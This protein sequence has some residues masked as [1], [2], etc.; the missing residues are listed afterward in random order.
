MSKIADIKAKIK[1]TLDELVT[2]EVLALVIE[3]N[4]KGGVFDR[5]YSAFP[6]AILETP[7][8][9]NE[10]L[11]NTQNFRTYT[12]RLLVL[13]K[14]ENVSGAGAIENLI[15]A[16][17]DK[18][19]QGITLDGEADGGVEPSSSEPAAYVSRGKDYVVFSITLR[20]K[21]VKDLTFTP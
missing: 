16:I 3:E 12:F 11:T 21:A 9:A 17:I 18:F 5:D 13:Q 15:E 4:Y 20:A 8:V 14:L 6:V 2:D 10:T 7:A 19:D 1:A